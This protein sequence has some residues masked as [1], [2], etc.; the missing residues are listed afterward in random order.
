MAGALSVVV[1][2]AGHVHENRFG[3]DGARLLAFSFA[4]DYFE[5]FER[6]RPREWYWH[7]GD[8]EARRALRLCRGAARAGELHTSVLDEVAALL[9]APARDA[10]PPRGAAPC[11]LLE[12]RARIHD[13]VG[14]PPSVEA[15]ARVAGV[16]R[17]TLAAAF[18]RHF[19][20]TVTAYHRR[21]RLRAAAA[22]LATTD[23][24]L[25][26]IAQDAGFTDQ[27]H[28]TRAFRAATGVTPG[29]FRAHA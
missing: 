1:K 3:P 26:A 6:G 21:L 7:H 2:P 17:V 19:G 18:R 28:F 5:G 20:L 29:A 8:D 15:L 16:H 22:A 14:C 24:P 10:A 23:A 12:T 9:L 25:A 11:W 4:P 13:S 27:P